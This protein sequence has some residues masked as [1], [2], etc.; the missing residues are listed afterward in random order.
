MVRE[1][2]VLPRLKPSPPLPQHRAPRCRAPALPGRAVANALVLAF[3]IQPLVRSPPS[4]CPPARARAVLPAQ[5]GLSLC[6][7]S[8]RVLRGHVPPPR[9]IYGHRVSAGIAAVPVC[10]W[11]GSVR[12][13]GQ[14]LRGWQL[15]LCERYLLPTGAAGAVG[16][17]AGAPH[18]AGVLASHRRS[19]LRR[20]EL[21]VGGE[22]HPEMAPRRGVPAVS[23]ALRHRGQRQGESGPWIDG[24][25]PGSGTRARSSLLCA[26]VSLSPCLPPCT[27]T[28][29][30]LLPCG[31]CCPPDTAERPPCPA[32][33]PRLSR[34]LPFQ[35]PGWLPP[36]RR[37][38]GAR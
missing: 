17:T 26:S 11:A 14:R 4:V 3:L 28:L 27:Q 23:G 22:T 33:L 9:S 8:G 34:L 31:C 36:P 29:L 20:R 18:R 25:D 32:A 16:P 38:S 5:R 24:L 35:E 30:D 19:P 6:P 21:H 2:D 37:W 7:S 10:A 13:A 15:A 1:G 12:G